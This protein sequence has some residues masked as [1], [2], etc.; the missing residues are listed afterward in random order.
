MDDMINTIERDG[1]K[2]EELYG[3]RLM[4][5]IAVRLFNKYGVPHCWSSTLVSTLLSNDYQKKMASK[6]GLEAFID[7][8]SP[9]RL[10]DAFEVVIIL[11]LLMCRY[12][13]APLKEIH[14]ICSPT[15][16]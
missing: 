5:Q 2:M 3:D 4:A 14:C 15:S 13:G 10:A 8:T 12:F 9:K 6:Q 7:S 16:Q 1:W 11:I